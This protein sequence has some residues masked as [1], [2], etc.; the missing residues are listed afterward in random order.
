MKNVIE[1]N[2]VEMEHIIVDGGSKDRTV[3]IVN[4]YS[5]NYP[6]I[7]WISEK[8]KGQ[9]DAMNKGIRMA[10]TEIIGIL[11][12]DDYYEPNVLNRVLEIFSTL[13]EVSFITGNCKSWNGGG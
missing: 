10:K 12:V 5:E 6:H 7:R 9:S 8:D 1:Q 2:C 13:I 3:E 11:N 4:N